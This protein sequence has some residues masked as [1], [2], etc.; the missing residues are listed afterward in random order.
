MSSRSAKTANAVQL[1]VLKKAMDIQAQGAMQLIESA[2]QVIS[3]NPPNLGNK[4]NS[5]A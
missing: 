1:T 5:F 2:S 4:V 3:N